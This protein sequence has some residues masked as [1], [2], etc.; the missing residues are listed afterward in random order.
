MSTYKK[1]E[2]AATNLNPDNTEDFAPEYSK[3]E[4]LYLLAKYLVPAGFFIVFMEYYLLPKFEFYV[5]NIGCYDYNWFT[6]YELVFYGLF[7]GFPLVLA[8][9]LF[10]IEGFRSLKVI[11]LNQN[12]LPNEKVWKP[13]K[14]SYGFRAKIK[15]LAFL[16][17]L[18]V[19]FILGVFGAYKA[20]KFLTST[21]LEAPMS[22]SHI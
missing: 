21:N 2:R 4:K 1:P 3:K 22:C 17:T 11:E 19:L 15:P 6:G 9:V 20:H 13:T 10:Y 8:V 16:F 14:Y 12:P 5:E 7:S 18:F